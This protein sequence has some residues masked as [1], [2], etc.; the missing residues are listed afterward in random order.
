MANTEYYE[1]LGVDKN[2]SDA[3]IKS[4]YKKCAMKCHP[5]RN[6][7]NEAKA[8]EE[9]KKI[10]EAYS[11]L[12][13]P[14]KKSHYDRFGKT[15]G[16]GSMPGAQ[17]INDI[18]RN[19][20]G[21]GGGVEVD[22]GSMFGN[23]FGGGRHQNAKQANVIHCEVT[24]EEVY[25]GTLKHIEYEISNSCHACNG[26]GA[27]DPKDIIKCMTCNGEGNITQRLGP[28]FIT[29]STCPSCFGNGTSIKTNRKCPNCN[30]NKEANYK[31]KI[32]MEVPCGIPEGYQHKLDGKG[33]YNKGSKCNNDL[34]IIFHYGNVPSNVAVQDNGDIKVGMEIKF[35]ELLC[36]FSKKL[37]L[38]GKELNITS[39][40]FFNVGKPVVF[41]NKGMPIHKR[42]S[43]HGDLIIQFKV[44]YSDDM[45][46]KKYNDVFLK[47]FK[48][49]AISPEKDALII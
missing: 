24:L 28:M 37:D 1:I 13:D 8:E 23:M 43:T 41:K 2:A 44:E 32:K 6:H 17:D 48:R 36:G 4:A 29:Q 3:E 45:V 47:I 31:K 26:L 20:F 42:T 22:I 49:D 10:T 39:T 40:G 21:G 30:G 5:D 18:F 15:E 35:E 19:M 34:V 7:G 38:Y 25:N 27:I 46:I 9:F 14:E 33:C 16:G 11:V 12:S